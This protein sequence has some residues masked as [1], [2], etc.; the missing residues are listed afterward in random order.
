[1]R[2]ARG[3]IVAGELGKVHSIQVEYAQ[4]WLTTAIEDTGQKQAEWRTDPARSGP[5]GCLGDIGTHAFNLA[6][7]VTGLTCEQVAADVSALVRGRRVPDSARLL[8]RFS[9]EAT[10][11]LWAT[12]VA[13]GNGNNLRLRVFGEKAGLEWSQEEPE[14][15]WYGRLGAPRQVIRRGGAG[16]TPAAARASRL[17]AGHPEGYL[18]AFAQ[19]YR[20]LAEQIQAAKQGRKP[21]PQ[22]LLVPG[23][24][25]GIEEM[26]FVAAA[27]ESSR[28]NSAWIELK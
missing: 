13:P 3:M 24:D 5:G 9:H 2:Q 27:L 4:D 17:P 11:M 19:L 22:S 12:Q 26:Q 10:G 18:E 21:D 6:S 8:L 20:D 23:I 28:R 14:S 16:T 1:V 7:F 15:L 25:A